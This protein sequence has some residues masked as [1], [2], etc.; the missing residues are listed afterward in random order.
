MINKKKLF[1][2]LIIIALLIIIIF[3][4]IQ[5][6]RTL[7]RYETTT[8]T[9]RDVDVA[10]WIVDNSF[11]SQRLYINDIYPKSTAFEYPFTVANYDPGADLTSETDD[12]IAETDMEYEILLK[13]TTNLPLSYEIIR[14]G[15]ICAQGGELYPDAEQSEL[16][17]DTDG[18]VYRKIEIK[19]TIIEGETTRTIPFTI[20]TIND[21]TNQKQKITDDFII[22]VTFPEEYSANENYADLMEYVDIELTARQVIAE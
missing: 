15:A 4:V 20:N 7:A 14:E 6:G 18:T 9:N 16:Y 17:T 3:A 21:D 11:D 13:T 8:T 5:I 19:Q 10:F 1:K 22:K 2:T 12:K